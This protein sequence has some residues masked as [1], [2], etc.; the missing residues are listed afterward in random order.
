MWL[1]LASLAVASPVSDAVAT[2]DCAAVV[3]ALPSP[4]SPGEHL[5]LGWCQLR[6][7]QVDT[8]AITLSAVDGTD[9]HAYGR[10]VRAEALEGTDPV[11]AADLLDG[12]SL[13]GDT[14]LQVRLARG[15]ALVRAERSLD[16]REGLRQLLDTDVGAEARYWLAVGGEQRGAT[17]AAVATYQRAWATSTRGPWSDRA[18]ERLAA[19]GHPVPD[20]ATPEGRALVQ[21]RIVALQADHQHA[22]AL[23]LLEE[24]RPGP[25][26]WARSL[27]RAREYPRAIQ[28]WAAVLGPPAAA[29]GTP[30]ELFDYALTHARTGDYDTAAVVYRR[31]IEQHPT[32]READ[33]AS[34]KL[35]YMEVDRGDLGAAI[36]LLEAHVRERPDS[37]HLDEALWFLGRARW[38]HGDR[39]GAVAAWQRLVASRSSSSLVPAARYWTARAAGLSGDTAAE[40]SGLREVLERHPVSG[41]AW[42]AA[43]RLEHTFPARPVVERPAWPAALANDDRVRRAELLLAVGFQEW[44]AAELA[45]VPVRGREATLA[46]AHA[47]IA[48]GDAKGGARLA[49]SYCVSPWKDG[50]PVAQQACTPRPAAPI[51]DALTAEYGLPALLPFGIMQAESALDPS[52]TSW[53][54]ARGLMQI[55]PAEGP[56]LHR[57]RFG[58]RP[59]DPDDLYRVPYNAS[60]GT[61]ELG[62]KAGS[63]EGVLAGGTD[64]PAVIASYN[65]GEEAVR[66]WLA[67]Y[68]TAPEFDEFAEDISYTESRRYVRRVLGFVMR[69]RWVYGDQAP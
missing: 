35:G 32:S 21:D 44:A 36:P 19:L 34:F 53:A 61:T 67:A 15:R 40:E 30:S 7:G 20:R 38:R 10:W 4:A 65:G 23:V 63:L 24:D 26:T 11:A 66:R 49:S 59:C 27:A 64:L 57:A 45:E 33:L 62:M 22:A 5:A 16:A 51:V 46:M 48:A 29:T 12:V 14:G 18:A 9:L 31:L 3:H 6:L 68:E 43:H 52:V 58:E 50:Q 8:A 37:Q 25:R 55:M 41:Y 1:V 39:E 28:A 42:F 2:G 54:G 17:Q 60:L 69:Y 13:P 56:R 47:R